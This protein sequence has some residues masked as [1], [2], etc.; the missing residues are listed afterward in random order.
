MARPGRFVWLLV[1]GALVWSSLVG[2]HRVQEH[3]DGRCAAGVRALC[4]SSSAAPGR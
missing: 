2:A 3:R 1:A 4:A